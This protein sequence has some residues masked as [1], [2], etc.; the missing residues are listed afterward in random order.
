[1]MGK[2]FHLELALRQLRMALTQPMEA[3]IATLLAAMYVRM[4]PMNYKRHELRWK[5]ACVT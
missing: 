4:T 5:K 3:L 2:A 1:M